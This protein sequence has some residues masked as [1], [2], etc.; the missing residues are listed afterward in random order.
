MLGSSSGHLTVKRVGID[1]HVLENPCASDSADACSQQS[2]DD[3]GRQL[4]RPTWQNPPETALSMAE[5]PRS[6][7]RAPAGLAKGGG[8]SAGQV[9]KDYT[10]NSWVTDHLPC[11]CFEKWANMECQSHVG[12]FMKQDKDQSLGPCVDQ[13]LFRLDN[14]VLSNPMACNKPPLFQ[15]RIDKVVSS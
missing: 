14:N 12:S 6:A 7:I 2:W 8:Q 4:E 10:N 13:Q 11:L 15:V 9:R 3:L 5:A 1:L